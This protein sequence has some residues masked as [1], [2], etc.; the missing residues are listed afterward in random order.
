MGLSVIRKKFKMR[1]SYDVTLG[2]VRVV[3]V[4]PELANNLLTYEPNEKPQIE[5]IAEAITTE[6]EEVE[7]VADDTGSEDH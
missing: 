4:D 6:E 3:K 5:M 1:T 7:E 2:D